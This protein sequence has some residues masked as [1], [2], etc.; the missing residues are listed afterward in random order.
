MPVTVRTATE[1][2]LPALTRLDLTYPAGKVLAVERSDDAPQHTFALRWRA[3]DAPDAVYN[4]YTQDGLRQALTGTDVFLAAE[5]DGRIAGLLMIVAP[6]WTDAAEIT[7]LAV[8]RELRHRGAGSALLAT[9]A[10]WARERRL[11]AL[12]AEPRADNREA[13]EFYLAA[14]FR[15]S[16]FNDRLY[17]NR[18]DEPGRTTLFM[19]LEL[20]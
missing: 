10:K 9:A 18:D 14:G 19:H 15:V 8:D 6:T 5:V 20:A 1:G 11:R 16:G 13:I 4:R 2:D 7:D 3:H 12:W 17:S